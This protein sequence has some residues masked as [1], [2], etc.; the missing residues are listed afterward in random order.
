MSEINN[1]QTKE[2]TDISTQSNS[3]IA[4]VLLAK[5][6]SL[7]RKLKELDAF[8]TRIQ[9]EYSL[10]LQEIQQQ[11]KPLKE[12]LY[13]IEALIKFDS[14]VNDYKANNIVPSTSGNISITD[15]VY[16]LLS[17]IHQPIHYR[18]IA[19]KLLE[20]NV[21]I[22]GKDPAAT[23]LSRINR[24]KRFKRIKKRGVYALSTWRVR[25][26]KSKSRGNRKRSTS[27]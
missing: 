15:V 13:H 6:E 26:V 19:H 22:P 10:K 5:R 3:N 7:R 4:D 14:N 23:L 27:K 20:K 17:E 11:K 16:N 2:D 18:D 21:Y 9:E 24:D 12:T 25:G 8:A 1:N